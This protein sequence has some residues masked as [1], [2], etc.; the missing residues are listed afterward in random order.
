MNH[1]C[2]AASQGQA[3][4]SEEARDRRRACTAGGAAAKTQFEGRVWLSVLAGDYVILKEA[5]LVV[6]TDMKVS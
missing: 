2:H 5:F 4:A 3:V 6:I 1:Q